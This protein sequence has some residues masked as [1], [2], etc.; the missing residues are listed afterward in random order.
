MDAVAADG[1]QLAVDEF[2]GGVEGE[3]V[4]DGGLLKGVEATQMVQWVRPGLATLLATCQRLACT[5]CARSS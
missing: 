2:A 4:G 5:E 1:D 3:R